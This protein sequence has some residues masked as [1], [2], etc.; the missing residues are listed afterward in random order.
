MGYRTNALSEVLADAR[1]GISHQSR[2]AA[3]SRRPERPSAELRITMSSWPGASNKSLPSLI[4]MSALQKVAKWRMNTLTTS[5]LSC[6]NSGI[7]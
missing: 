7:E 1:R 2:F 4:W 3:N 6:A 5:G